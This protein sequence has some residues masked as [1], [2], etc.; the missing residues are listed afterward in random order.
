[1]TTANLL[2]AGRRPPALQVALYQ[3]SHKG[4]L[5]RR[6][7]RSGCGVARVLMGPKPLRLPSRRGLDES[8]VSGNSAWLRPSLEPGDRGIYSTVQSLQGPH[9]GRSRGLLN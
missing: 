5:G 1:M 9:Q 2:A 7:G 4:S 6:G 3:L 8:C